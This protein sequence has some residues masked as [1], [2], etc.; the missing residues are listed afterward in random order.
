MEQPRL[1]PLFRPKL[2]IAT[3]IGARLARASDTT[4]TIL[5][6]NAHPVRLKGIQQCQYGGPHTP[7]L[8]MVRRQYDFENASFPWLAANRYMAGALGDDPINREEP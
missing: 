7:L 1:F 8:L 4:N 5:P 3:E 2:W 6:G